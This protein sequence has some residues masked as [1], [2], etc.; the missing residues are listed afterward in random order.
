MALGGELL[1]E[2]A[3]ELK[4]T[5]GQDIFVFG[6]SNDVMAYIPSETVLKE[7]G[8][9]GTRSPVFTTAWNMN[10]QKSILE[11]MTRLAV[12]AGVKPVK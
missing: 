5:F 1:V 3:I 2:Y 9:E 11:E 12:K 7:G 10:I 8:Y 4:K 6:Y